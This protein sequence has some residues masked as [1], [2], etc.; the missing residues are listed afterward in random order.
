MKIGFLQFAPAFG[1]KEQNL[2]TIETLLS[3][4]DADIIVLPE[5]ALSG[6]FFTRKD[7]VERTAEEVPGPSTERLAALARKN[8]LCLVVGMVE[9]AADGI[10]N[11]AVLI[12]PEGVEGV[13]RKVHLFASE[14]KY[15]TPGDL[16]FPLF[17][18]KGASIGMLVCF[19]HMFPEAARTLALRGAEIIL[20][21]ANLV[22]PEYA[23]L[24]TRVRAIENRVF[25]VMAN[26]YGSEVRKGK[27][28]LYTGRS[29]II[30]QDGIVLSEAPENGDHL[31]VVDIDPHKALDKHVSQANDLFADRRKDL[32]EL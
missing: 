4:V 23:Q 24:T 29:Q 7:E 9:K 21:P 17:T 25:W 1:E 16:G 22:I 28:L 6:Y 8:S 13:Y 32:Y 27:T 19:D 5:L 18:V 3:G 26:R 14:K 10:F 11:S 31:R 20:H 30:A 15:F 2:C 12:G